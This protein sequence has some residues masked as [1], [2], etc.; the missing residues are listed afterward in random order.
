MNWKFID[1]NLKSVKKFA[2]SLIL[3]ERA[4]KGDFLEFLLS[5]GLPGYLLFPIVLSGLHTGYQ[6]LVARQRSEGILLKKTKFVWNSFLRKIRTNN[7]N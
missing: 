2:I 6:L 3:S 1:F 5:D 4:L 7:T